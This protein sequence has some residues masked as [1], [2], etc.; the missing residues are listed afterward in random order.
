MLVSLAWLAYVP[1]PFFAFI[2]A[3]AEKH[4]R[5]ERFHAWQGGLQTAFLFTGLILIGL[6]GR[7]SNA[8]GFVKFIG[9]IA[10]LWIVANLVA[11]G[12][13]LTGALR[14][15]YGRIRPAFDVLTM[16]GR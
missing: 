13:G 5:F 11:L 15:Q 9:V 10:A 6:L 16:L 4:G 2:P 7:A 1:I 12:F 8:G 3:L 14:G